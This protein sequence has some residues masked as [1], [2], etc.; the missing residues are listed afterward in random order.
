MGFFFHD[1]Y[2]SSSKFKRI[3]KIIDTVDDFSYA[4]VIV[5]WEQ[6]GKFMSIF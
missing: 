4:Q 6:Q 3:V 5:Q 2:Y 1:N